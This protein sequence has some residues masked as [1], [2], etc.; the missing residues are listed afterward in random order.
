METI[1]EPE[2]RIYYF[3]IILGA[4]NELI[5]RG[6]TITNVKRVR[7]VLNI[8]A[9]NRSKIIF[10]SRTLEY[11]EEKGY[12]ELYSAKSPKSYRLPREKISLRCEK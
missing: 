4:I 5:E 2:I 7:N 12:I 9:E 10:I 6:K 1:R 3:D 8:E 11:L